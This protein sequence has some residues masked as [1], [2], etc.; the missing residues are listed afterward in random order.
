MQFKRVLIKLRE[1]VI[2]TLQSCNSFEALLFNLNTGNYNTMLDKT[3]KLFNGFSK[4]RI[5]LA[6][7]DGLVRV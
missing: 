7:V 5:K 2:T 6:H 3:K 1:I 4:T